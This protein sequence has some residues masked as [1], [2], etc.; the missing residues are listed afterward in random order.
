MK[1]SVADRTTCALVGTVGFAVLAV[2]SMMFFMVRAANDV[3]EETTQLLAA[4]AIDAQ[5]ELLAALTYDYAYWDQA[6]LWITQRDDEAV[7]DNLGT[8]ASTGP[9]FYHIFLLAPDG[10]PIY[11]YQR[12]EENS[13]LSFV[14]TELT[15]DL[16]DLVQTLPAVPYDVVSGLALVHG[17]IAF[18]A[19]GRVEFGQ[20]ELDPSTMPVMVATRYIDDEVLAELADGLLLDNFFVTM[21]ASATASRGQSKLDLFGLSGTALGSVTWTKPTPGTEIFAKVLPPFLILSGLLFLGSFVIGQILRR[22]SNDLSDAVASAERDALTGLMNRRGLLKVA[23]ERP[24]VDALRKGHLALIYVDLN[25]FKA[26]ND[27]AGHNAGDIALQTAAENLK[28]AVRADDIVA[29]LGGDE[30][31]VIL[32]SANR[33]E[34]SNLSKRISKNLRETHIFVDRE[35]LVE[36]AVGVA[37]AKENSDFDMLMQQADKAMYAS[38]RSVSNRP[39]F[40]DS[41]TYVAA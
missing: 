21:D 23:R 12:G 26:L 41:E 22:K 25:G 29:R 27:G 24:V 3:A 11:G 20:G 17:R 10:T 40:F 13:D 37:V 39:V 6:Y 15:S 7:F 28:M 38:K 30:F 1:T 14:D 32:F 16:Y 4:R 5:R 36:G 31:L 19:A 34:I 8:S 33:G 9:H 35:F 2:M 18:V